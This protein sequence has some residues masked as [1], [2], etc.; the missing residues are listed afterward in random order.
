MP[1]GEDQVPHLELTREIARRFNHFYGRLFPEPQARLTPAPRLPGTDGRKMSKSY[2]NA[3]FL[4]DPPKTVSKKVDGMLT[5]PQRTHRHIPGDPGV[6]PVF[7]T[8]KVFSE[9]D[10]VSWADQGCRTAE[11]GCRDCKAALKDSI[12]R[13][14]EPITARRAELSADPGRVDRILERGAEEARTVARQTMSDVR[15]A[16]HVGR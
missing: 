8:H 10:T 14:L 7:Q 5:D 11:I 12:G 6:C 3:I 15:K 9:Q 2:D 4:S 16:T 1:V 13:R